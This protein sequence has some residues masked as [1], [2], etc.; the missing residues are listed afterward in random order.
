MIKEDL[1]NLPTFCLLRFEV[2]QL[3]LLCLFKLLAELIVRVN[4]CSCIHDTVKH[5][6]IVNG[7]PL[8]LFFRPLVVQ[9]APRVLAIFVL[10]LE[11]VATWQVAF[12]HNRL[13]IQDR[14]QPIVD[15]FVLHINSLL[16]FIVAA[17]ARNAP[18]KTFML[19]I[20][21]I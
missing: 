21:G 11:F 3:V 13:L 9:R 12:L 16:R 20:R 18:D 1:L 15:A 17:L 2:K 6:H 14:L 7:Y 4:S 8:H 5:A 10:G 19:I